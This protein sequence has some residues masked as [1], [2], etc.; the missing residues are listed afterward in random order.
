MAKSFFDRFPAGKSISIE[1][2]MIPADETEMHAVTV[3]FKPMLAGG[4]LRAGGSVDGNG[5]GGYP[6]QSFRMPLACIVSD[7]GQDE[8]CPPICLSPAGATVW[9]RETF[10]ERSMRC[11]GR[12]VCEADS[13]TSVRLQ[14]L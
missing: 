11:L 7:I 8:R 13:L 10:I 3:Q 5:A 12:S 2:G 4:E 14:S 6:A 1:L 9:M